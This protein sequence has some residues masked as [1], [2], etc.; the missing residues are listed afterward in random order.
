MNYL[1]K[2]PISPARVLIIDEYGDIAVVEDNARLLDVLCPQ[3]AVNL[4]SR[5]RIEAMAATIH[6]EPEESNLD[7][8]IRALL[9]FLVC[10]ILFLAIAYG[11]PIFSNVSS[12]RS[13][14]HAR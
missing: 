3:A 2:L 1:T 7:A 4:P 10:A 11:G 14:H 13:S 12:P 9:V 5:A 8:G 6:A